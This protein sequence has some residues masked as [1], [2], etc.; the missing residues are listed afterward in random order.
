ML[1]RW[2]STVESPTPQCRQSSCPSPPKPMLIRGGGFR[3]PHP[4]RKNNADPVRNPLT[5]LAGELSGVAIDFW[6]GCGAPEHLTTKQLKDLGAVVERRFVRRGSLRSDGVHGSASKDPHAA[7]EV[8]GAGNGATD[9]VK[10]ARRGKPRIQ[11]S[12]RPDGPPRQ[13][14]TLYALFA[15]SIRQAVQCSRR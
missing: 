1:Q 3:D 4:F 7:C 10:R 8:A 2:F 5:Q 6:L 12:R 11:P 9:T 13:F 14:P 15:P